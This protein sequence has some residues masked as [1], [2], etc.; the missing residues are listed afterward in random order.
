MPFF[1]LE[2]TQTFSF[3]VRPRNVYDPDAKRQE[4]LSKLVLLTA[5]STDTIGKIKEKISSLYEFG[6]V[7]QKLVYR[8]RNLQNDRTLAES[9]I[10]VDSIIDLIWGSGLPGGVSFDLTFLSCDCSVFIRLSIV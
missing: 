3:Y 7:E 10:G 1:S 2:P 8:S 5:S 9:G 4:E 6:P